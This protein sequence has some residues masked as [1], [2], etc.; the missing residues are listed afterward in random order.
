MQTVCVLTPVLNARVWLPRCVASVADQEGVAVRHLILDGKSSD[1][2][3]EWLEAHGRPWNPDEDLAWRTGETY[4]LEWISAPDRGMY[5]ALNRGLTR[6]HEKWF[7]WLNADE[8]YLPGALKWRMDLAEQRPGI[9]I[10]IGDTLLVSPDGELLS[11]RKS[12]G[13]LWPLIAATDLYTPSCAMVFH[14]R[15]LDAQVQFDSRW[16]SVADEL[17][18]VE[19][20]RRGFRWAHCGR[21]VAASCVTGE[22]LSLSAIAMHETAELKRSYPWWTRRGRPL[23]QCARRAWKLVWGAWR[24]PTPLVYEIYTGS[25]LSKRHRFVVSRPSWRWP[26]DQSLPLV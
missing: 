15:V 14:R 11:W 7:A 21:T 5:E 8:Q 12:A 23:W 18:V 24:P 6:L 10:W 19:V 13:L 22:N 25:N 26:G 3:V 1:G 9:S 17:F 2:T 16:K 20:L 4:R